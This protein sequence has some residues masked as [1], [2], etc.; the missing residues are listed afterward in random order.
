[1]LC[2]IDRVFSLIVRL[3]GGDGG[4]GMDDVAGFGGGCVC[5]HASG[6]LRKL[7]SQGEAS[8]QCA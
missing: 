4:T 7:C 8:G 5:G 3:I 6:Q 1:M 2:L